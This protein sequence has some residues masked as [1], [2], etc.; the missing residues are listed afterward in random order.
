MAGLCESPDLLDIGQQVY[1]SQFY[2]D[3]HNWFYC[4]R[5]S[6]GGGDVCVD[7]GGVFEVVE[8]GG[9]IRQMQ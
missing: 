3:V 1:E 5:V 8:V 6:D 9:E 7:A 2:V 4:G